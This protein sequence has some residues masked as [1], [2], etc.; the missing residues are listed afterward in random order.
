MGFK[1]RNMN[2]Q[3][4]IPYQTIKA[5][6]MTNDKRKVKNHVCKLLG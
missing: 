1:P 2:D 6:N 3:R 5:I 4:D